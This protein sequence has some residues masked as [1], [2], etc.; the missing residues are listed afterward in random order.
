LVSDLAE[1]GLFDCAVRTI[2]CRCGMRQ[3]GDRRD[4]AGAGTRHQLSSSPHRA[5]RYSFVEPM[6]L[7]CI[8]RGKGKGGEA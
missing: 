2:G 5:S 3:A 7:K 4:T 8:A 6:P 1:G